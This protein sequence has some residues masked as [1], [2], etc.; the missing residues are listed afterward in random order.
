MR[1]PATQA[2]AP[3]SSQTLASD[4]PAPPLEKEPLRTLYLL[5]FR[6]RGGKLVVCEHGVE[7]VDLP[8]H[9]LPE[10]SHFLLVAL[11]LLA[12]PSPVTNSSDV[13]EISGKVMTVVGTPKNWATTL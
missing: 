5:S 3:L 6:R 1:A 13:F 7:R 10:G 12:L 4:P 8:G 11:Q 9:P 2:T